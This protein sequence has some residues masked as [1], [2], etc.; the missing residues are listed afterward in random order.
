MDKTVHTVF[1]FRTALMRSPGSCQILLRTGDKGFQIMHMVEVNRGGHP[2]IILEAIGVP[3][4]LVSLATLS[5]GNRFRFQE[6]LEDDLEV[7]Q[8]DV[9]P[10]HELIM[11]IRHVREGW[12]GRVGLMTGAV[13]WDIGRYY[14]TR[15]LPMRRG[16]DRGLRPPTGDPIPERRAGR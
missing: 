15:V 4:D 6:M 11:E 13:D 3:D 7:V 10:D 8:V 14:D 5:P 16:E 1:D 9:E 12:H 2:S